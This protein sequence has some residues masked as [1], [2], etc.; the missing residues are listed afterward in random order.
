MALIVERLTQTGLG[1]L[2]DGALVERV[3]PGEEVEVADGIARILTPSA[4]RVSPPCRHFKTCGGCLVQH[5]SDDFV[6]NWKADIVRHALR[7]Q[8]LP[9]DIARIATSPPASRRRATFSG[10]RTKKGA[11]VGFFGRGSD[12]IIGVTEC[13]VLRPALTGAIPMLEDLTRRICSRTNTARYVVTESLS[14]LDLRIDLDLKD[15]SDLRRELSAFAAEHGLARLSLGDDPI[16]VLEA[17]TQ[18][19][20]SA[21]V[22]PP[23]GAFL[24]ATREGE[25]ALVDAVLNGVQGAKRVVDLFAGCGTFSLPLASFANVHAVESGGDMLRALDAGYRGAPGLHQVSTEERDLFRRPLLPDE[26]SDYD[27]AV[28]DPPRAGAE[29]QIAEVAMARIAKVMM[30]SC[31]PVTYA[32]DAKTLLDAEYRMA[33][34]LIVDQFRWSSHIEIASQFTLN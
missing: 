33:P 29:A 21:K 32:R 10:R 9:E 18:L 24:Q 25:A 31:N 34:V 1:R 19:F 2:S 7:G 3:L 4:E 28:I 6:A 27:A 16:V 11:L 30:V 12:T 8:G 20:G 15:T 26:L 5:A 22:T 13:K 23:P 14:G 17:P